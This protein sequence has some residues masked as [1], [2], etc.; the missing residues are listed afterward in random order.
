MIWEAQTQLKAKTIVIDCATAAICKMMLKLGLR[1]SLTMIA[2]VRDQPGIDQM[3]EIGVEHVLNVSSETFTADMTKM[4]EELKPELFIDC[5]NSDNI[6]QKV[7]NAMPFGS[8]CWLFGCFESSGINNGF[9]H[10]KNVRSWFVRIFRETY[11]QYEYQLRMKAMSDILPGRPCHTKINKKFPLNK[12][13]AALESSE[14]DGKNGKTCFDLSYQF[15]NLPEIEQAPT[16]P[17]MEYV[18]LGGSG[19]LVSR[20]GYGNW[21]TSAGGASQKMNELVKCAYDHGVNFFDTAEAY[22]MGL[23]EQQMGNAIRA[24][25]CPR[26]EVIVATKIFWGGVRGANSKL[27][28]NQFG[29]SRKHMVEGMD[30]SLK[31]LKMDYVDVVFCHRYD[32]HTPMKET[33]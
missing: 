15:E 5:L 30:R 17:A 11:Q 31:N 29:T 12:W 21:I 33:L 13:E 22:D 1:D 4:F 10:L 18:R 2:V 7:Y 3:K 6:T 16:M 19:L 25:G 14:K 24:L 26:N 9:F 23:G 20:I 28:Q 32:I 8:S 27:R